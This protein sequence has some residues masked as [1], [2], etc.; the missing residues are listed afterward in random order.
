MKVSRKAISPRAALAAV[1]AILITVT[2][3]LFLNVGPASAATVNWCHDPSL[4]GTF[5]CFNNDYKN[6]EVWQ[7]Y[8]NGTKQ[9]FVSGLD[10]AL[11]T[12]WDK[13]NGTWSGWTSMGGKIAR[14]TTPGL[15][16]DREYTWVPFVVVYGTD[17]RTWCRGRYRSGAWWAWS[18]CTL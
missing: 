17:N 16:A 18:R 14:N 6:G 15:G 8:P 11:W 5:V 1:S 13:T 4:H 7:Y 12:R 10:Y 9:V 3:T 2:V